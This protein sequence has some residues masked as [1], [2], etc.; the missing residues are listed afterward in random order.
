MNRLPLPQLLPRQFPPD[1][2]CV[3]CPL[4]TV[5]RSVGIPTHLLPESRPPSP[6]TPAVLIIGQN[7]GHTE[8]RTGTPFVGPTGRL[9]RT[10]YVPGVHLHT[11]AT[12]Y[13]SNTARC[14][15]RD[16]DGPKPAVYSACRSHLLP[17]LHLLAS[18]HPLHPLLLITLGAPATTHT[19]ALLGRPKV[20]L[21]SSFKHQLSAFPLP[22]I[23]DRLPLSDTPAPSPRA[24]RSAKAV[25]P[26]QLPGQGE[27]PDQ[28]PTSPLPPLPVDG[29]S[30]SAAP[31]PDKV[32]GNEGATKTLVGRG[33]A[34]TSDPSLSPAGGREGGLGCLV[35]STYHPAAVLRSRN[36]IYA[37]EGHLRLA[38]DHLTGHTPAPSAPTIAPFRYPLP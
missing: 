6:S 20:T 4:H 37:V 11:L 24:R 36:L 18:L 26:S 38:M 33:V 25:K 35:V 16:G 9:L 32:T 27:R 21:T 34:S 30:S 15:H 14:Y 13:V 17:D 23:S 28:V 1:P 5:A 7:P 19:Y 29:E 12:I 3:R 10:V 22:P 8:D 31:P 2:S